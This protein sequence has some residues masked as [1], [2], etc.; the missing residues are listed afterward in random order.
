MHILVFTE[1]DGAALPSLELLAHTIQTFPATAAALASAPEADIAIVDGVLDLV[2]AKHLCGLLEPTATPALV[3]V[4]EG[5]LAALS[6]AWGASDFV[7]HTASPA[8]VEARLKLAVSRAST[9]VLTG[10]ESTR[11]LSINEASYQ[12]TVGGKPIDLTYKE[13]ELLRFL[14]AHPARVFTREQILNGVWGHDYFGGTRTVDVHV[15]RLRAK[16]GDVESVIGTVRGVGYR[17]EIVEE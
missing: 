1:R 5:G 4:A 6:A 2:T 13:F 7:L 9:N 8:E 11:G 17:F 15:R 14:A 12:A 10:P 16:L 3:V